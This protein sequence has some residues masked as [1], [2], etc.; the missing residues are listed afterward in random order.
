MEIILVDDGSKDDS[1]ERCLKLRDK[2]SRIVVYHT[3]NQGSGPARNHGIKHASG[4]YIYFPDADDELDGS[5]ISKLVYAMQDGRFDLVVF[6]YKSIDVNG[7]I[8][9]KKAYPEMEKDGSD[10]RLDYSD[11]MGASRKYGIQGAPWN[12]FFSLETVKEYN[13]E[14][15]P[16]RRHQD[17]GFIS[18]YMCHTNKIHFINDV[19]YTHYLNTCLQAIKRNLIVLYQI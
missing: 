3:E 16:L 5:A 19:L 8:I 15:P 2:D 11:Y 1:L 17:E 14:Y 9:L 13:V 4:R 6:G 7:E 12:K 18:R 10:I